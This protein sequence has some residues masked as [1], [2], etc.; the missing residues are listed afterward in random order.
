M[1]QLAAAKDMYH[2]KNVKNASFV[3]VNFYVCFSFFLGFGHGPY[4]TIAINT[5]L[6]YLG[7]YSVLR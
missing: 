3:L 7:V 1:P 4:I 5:E 6:R 2:R